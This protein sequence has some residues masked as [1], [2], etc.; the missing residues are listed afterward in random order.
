MADFYKRSVDQILTDFKT[1]AERGLSSQE[2]AARQ[3]Q[4]GKNR[5]PTG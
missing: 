4:H 1:D 3:A 5:L 2:A